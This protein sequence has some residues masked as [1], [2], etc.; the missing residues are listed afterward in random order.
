MKTLRKLTA[1]GLACLA[2]L[3]LVPAVYAEDHAKSPK[4]ILHTF[5]KCWETGDAET[6]ESLLADDVRFAYPGG[7]FDKAELMETFKGYGDK[8]KDIKIYFWD[9]F[10]TD[11]NKNV[12]AYEFAA[13]DKVTG[14][15][16]CVGTGVWV[17]IKGGKIV[18]YRE[19]FDS[20]LAMRQTRG[21]LP[22][23]EGGEITPW[24]ETIWLRH[25]TID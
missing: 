22:L 16:T 9:V 2:C 25:E 12:T 20:E 10:I 5:L 1:T 18:D 23:D 17:K 11:G 24:P 6:F 8:K 7:S 15:R 14:K 4:E 13:T 21:E 19:W 3:L